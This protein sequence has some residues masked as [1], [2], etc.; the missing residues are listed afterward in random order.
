M[1]EPVRL[2]VWDLDET[3]WRGTLVEGGIR[4][5]VQAHH[6]IVVELARRGILSSI[7]SKNDE[8]SVVKV[9]EEQKILDYFVFPDISWD[10]KGPR[11]AALIEAVQLRPA[12]VMFID[13]N[14]R[15]LAEAKALIPDLQLENEEFIP[16]LLADPRFVG[17]DDSDLS[18]LKQY[19][20]LEARSEAQRSA[21]GGGH[22]FLRDSD[23]RVCFDH[24]LED[25]T[26]LDR[27]IELINRTN[28]LN[29]TKRRLPED[30]EAA[31][32]ILRRDTALMEVQAGLIRVVDRYGDYG[33][34]GFFMMRVNMQAHE[35][36]HRELI[37][38]CF[39]C[40]TLG[41]LVERWVYDYLERPKL[42]VVGE[43]VT[44]LSGPDVVDWVRL[45][46][47]SELFSDRKAKVSAIAPE[48][49][50]Y[51]GCEMYP[52][53]LYLKQYAPEVKVRGS[54]VANDKFIL[55][56]S[57]ALAVS[58]F[59]RTESE[60]CEEATALGVPAD[61]LAGDYFA[62][63]PPGTAIVFSGA[64]DGG[65]FSDHQ[66][67]YQHAHHGW[68]LAFELANCWDVTT[69]PEGAFERLVEEREGCD[70]A[71]RLHLTEVARHVRRNYRTAPPMSDGRRAATLWALLEHVPVG[72]KLILLLDHDRHRV[73]GV[74]QPEPRTAHYN[75]LVRSIV[76]AYP[77]AEA[78]C[79]SDF[80]DDDEQV[81]ELGNHY[82]RVVYLKLAERLAELIERLPRKRA[83]DVRGQEIV[84][85]EATVRGLYRDL[86][87]DTPRENELKVWS[88]Y[89]REGA[90]EGV[91]VP[92]LVEQFVSSE[93]YKSRS[94]ALRDAQKIP[95]MSPA[96]AEEYIASL[97]ATILKREPTPAE[98]AHWVT[99]AAAL[100]PEQLYFAFV[101]SK[102]Y[103]LRQKYSPT[104]DP[105]TIGEYVEKQYL[106]KPGDIKGIRL[107]EDAMA[108]FW[109]ENA[110]FIKNAPFSDHDD[111]KNRYYYD[112][113]VYP[114]GDA[115]TLRAMIAHFKP[116]NVIEVG[117]GF[118]SACM[119]DAVDDV[120]LSDFTLTCIDPDADRLR[121]RLREEDHSRVDIIEAQVQDVPVSTFS[122]LN[123]NDILFIDSTHVLKTASDVHYALFSIL[124]SL[125]KGVLVN[126]QAI[127]YPFEYP[128][129]WLFENNRSWN[130]IYA[131]R[132][133]LTYNSAFE[134]VFWNG[135]FAHRQRA[136]VHQTNPLF[137]KNP[138]GSIWLRA[139]SADIPQTQHAQIGVMG[140]PQVGTQFGGWISFGESGNS[141]EVIGPGW[142][143]QELAHRW[144]TGR[145]SVLALPMPPESNAADFIL[146]LRVTPYLANGQID[147]Q[148]CTVVC[149]AE[150][151]AEVKLALS[152]WI[153][154]RISAQAVV[155]EKLSILF[156]HPDAGS[157]QAFGIAPD[158]REL[159]IA[160]HEA[161][162]LPV[163]EADEL[164]GWRGKTGQFVSS[165]WRAQALAPDWKRIAS[166]FQSMGQDCEFGLVQR[167]CEAEPLGL[168]RWS[169]IM[170]HGLIQSL[171]TEFSE[172][173]DEEKLN[174]YP[175]STGEYHGE[176]KSLNMIYHTLV[177]ADQNPDVDAVRRKESTRLKMMVRLFRE[178][179]EDGEKV[180][181][182][183][184]KFAPLDEF[185]VLPV[186]SLMR[187]YNPK[188][189]LLWVTVA[190]P[191]ERHLVG[192]CEIV[193]N[194][195][196]KGYID[197]FSGWNDDWST[198]SIGC[199]KDILVS[200]LQALGRPIPTHA[201]GLSPEQKRLEL[202]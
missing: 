64:L 35:S 32:E 67:Y 7:C 173:T 51:G 87:G 185:E 125:N 89:A 177:L 171:R 136:L 42:E 169:N 49:R 158:S 201:E 165:D 40:R 149:G 74:V 34:V 60:F 27:A 85:A 63:A 138:G 111:G 65:R 172:L 48:L 13:D 9:L 44:D 105:S 100:P 73:Q 29:Y 155:S 103:K 178:D 12:T 52:I 77:Y 183:L 160:V 14:P 198:L 75:E 202:S 150:T 196:L 152:S 190:G 188:A 189:A 22:Q 37:H 21:G 151:V 112:N 20:L 91:T 115:M 24:D 25:V 47:S 117:S 30:L 116:K 192:Q 99:T 195:L 131:L 23:I 132:A 95:R 174:I 58:V 134:V 76:R 107:D 147:G 81:Q 164:M 50:L 26:N 139:R 166:T 17:K 168:F 10:P 61:V 72:A 167:Q 84:D 31:R 162:L 43:V 82:H 184:R 142:S 102:E 96:A 130:E 33:Y 122:K 145:F 8:Q 133:F 93:D 53:G 144:M 123:E 62:D 83:S 19:K 109:I 94:R 140:G 28:Q 1:A 148:R 135:L 5:Y 181:V 55:L 70:E 3:F 79:F 38:F 15:N 45:V 175:C 71:T 120:G 11:L 59:D 68:E 98:F 194:N 119:L 157:P 110:E 197:A 128:R 2:V 199:W 176:Y 159:A 124:P 127:S 121:S 104:V 78:V 156:I 41:M 180:F 118:S 108:R 154:F 18:R 126:F 6:E 179:L 141:K 69:L 161:V 86:L 90:R 97:Y 80:V 153:G 46:S 54:F 137:L 56:N 186:I 163:T 187:R 114:Y 143:F 191:D 113:G 16:K 92:D 88:A 4:E 200:A 146:M 106:Q 39:S 182:L 101:N 36:R 57:C 193:G 66:P 170:L 129:Q